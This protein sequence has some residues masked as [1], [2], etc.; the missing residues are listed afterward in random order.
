MYYLIIM[1]MYIPSYIANTIYHTSFC[2]LAYLEFQHLLENRPSPGL[3]AVADQTGLGMINNFG[4]QPTRSPSQ[5]GSL[6]SDVTVIARSLL[7]V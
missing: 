6:D 4:S 7:A 5:S 2:F 3:A 1:Y